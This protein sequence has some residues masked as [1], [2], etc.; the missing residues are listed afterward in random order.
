MRAN[1]LF[2]RSVVLLVRV[3]E[4]VMD[5]IPITRLCESLPASGKLAVLGT[6]RDESYP[7]SVRLPSTGC[8]SERDG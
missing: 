2:G 5:S 6:K 7:P 1:T 4:A 3:P 8:C